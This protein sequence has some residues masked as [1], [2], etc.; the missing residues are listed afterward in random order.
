MSNAIAIATCH[1]RMGGGAA[2]ASMRAYIEALLTD[3][4]VTGVAS[5]PATGNL[6]QTHDSAKPLSKNDSKRFHTIV[7][8]LLYL[9]KRTRPQILLAVAFLCTRVQD[10]TVCDQAKLSQRYQR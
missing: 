6:F 9:T 1:I 5:S 7:A 10:P 8:K 4:G 3:L 2:I